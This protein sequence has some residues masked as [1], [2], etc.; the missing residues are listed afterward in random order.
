MCGVTFKVFILPSLF[1]YLFNNLFIYILTDPSAVE[2]SAGFMGETERGLGIAEECCLQSGLE[3]PPKNEKRRKRGNNGACV[4]YRGRE[5]SL[6]MEGGMISK[7]P[8]LKPP[9]VAVRGLELESSGP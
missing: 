4:R 1:I 9:P 8:L 7:R 5:R 6:E 3:N 2:G